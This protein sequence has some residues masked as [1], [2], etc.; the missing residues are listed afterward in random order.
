MIMGEIKKQKKKRKKK[1]LY[2]LV[3]IYLL[4][5]KNIKTRARCKYVQS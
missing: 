2:N 4:K 1:K 3:G 5:V